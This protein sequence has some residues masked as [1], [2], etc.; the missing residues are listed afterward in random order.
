MTILRIHN[1]GIA[2]GQTSCF[3][4]FTTN[5]QLHK[6]IGLIGQNGSGKSSLMNVLAGF[7]EATFGKIKFAPNISAH[8][9]SQ[10][11]NQGTLRGGEAFQKCLSAAMQIS[12]D[13]LL[14][15]EPTNHLDQNAWQNLANTI[16]YYPGTV[17]FACHDEHFLSRLAD[18]IW[19]IESGKVRVFDCGY[20]E[21]CELKC[22][23]ADRLQM[24]QLLLLKHQRKL[25]Q[26]IA[27]EQHRSAQSRKANA[28][29]NDRK[30]VGA[31]I[32]KAGKTAA[33]HNKRLHEKK[34]LLDDIPIVNEIFRFQ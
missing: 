23:E 12:P 4:G 11:N 8:L 31:Y 1:L 32:E 3:E 34:E 28:N 20:Q 26:D 2:F 10:I 9:I 16:E 18:Q 30:L 21:F 7:S 25:R 5:V 6:R 17:V 33:K 19:E 22:H 13:L 14:L 27:F 15:D 29:E 24:Q